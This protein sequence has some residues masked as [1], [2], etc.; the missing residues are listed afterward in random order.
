MQIVKSIRKRSENLRHSMAANN[1]RAI[2]WRKF[3]DRF[4]MDFTICIILQ[5]TQ[6]YGPPKLVLSLGITC[7]VDKSLHF[8]FAKGL[9]TKSFLVALLLITGFVLDWMKA[10]LVTAILSWH[11]EKCCHDQKIG[12]QM[13]LKIKNPLLIIF[14]FV[15]WPIFCLCSGEC[16]WALC[17][18]QRSNHVY[19]Q[20]AYIISFW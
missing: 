3:S 17:L 10:Y 9:E 16:H 14:N 18:V 12:H 19:T 13:K 5:T 6:F 1:A 11:R 4:R 8:L 15:R 7:R 2:E 20:K